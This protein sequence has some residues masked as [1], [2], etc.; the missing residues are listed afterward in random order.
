MRPALARFEDIRPAA[1]FSCGSADHVVA[2]LAHAREAGLPLA[3]RS[4]GH[5]F[6]GRSS[7]DGVLIDVWPIAHVEVAEGRATIGAGARLGTI[8]DRLPGQ[9]GTSG[10]GGRAR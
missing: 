8:Y 9:G 2:A 6:A 5:C 7:T 10:G 4:G 1:H 3:V